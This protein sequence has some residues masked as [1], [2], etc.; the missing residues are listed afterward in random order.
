MSDTNLADRVNITVAGKSFVLEQ[1][2]EKRR[3]TKKN[4]TPSN[5]VYLRPYVEDTA[6][7][8]EF[9]AALLD[10][11]EAAKPESALALIDIIFGDY[12]KDVSDRLYV[13]GALIDDPEKIVAAFIATKTESLTDKKLLEMQAALEVETQ[14]LLML[15]LEKQT[16]PAGFSEK[17]TELGWTE[18]SFY[19]RAHAN[20]NRSKD[21][22]DLQAKRSSEKEER[23]KKRAENKDKAPAVETDAPVTA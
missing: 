12:W 21:L 20:K 11:A 22:A 10:T 23:A 9:V 13:N 19:Q 2:E 17:L 15:L 4:P 8:G 18:E 7:L 6:V 3:A 14:Q 16:N 5:L 1:V